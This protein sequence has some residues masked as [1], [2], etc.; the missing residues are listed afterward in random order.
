M[1]WN[2][3]V[4]TQWHWWHRHAV[5]CLIVITQNC[6]F[7]CYTLTGRWYWSGCSWF[8]AWAMVADDHE[9]FCPNNR[10][11]ISDSW[12]RSKGKQRITVG[13]DLPR[14]VCWKESNICTLGRPQWHS[15]LIH[16]IAFSI[17][18]CRNCWQQRFDIM[19]FVPL[20][21]RGWPS[22][23]V[24]LCLSKATG[25]KVPV[26]NLS[27]HPFTSSVETVLPGLEAKPHV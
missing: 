2:Q 18:R 25:F 13:A 12:T 4:P 1:S 24:E 27:L 15:F 3:P 11:P 19:I 7:P 22:H 16:F 26:T 9:L 5:Q 6:C 17:R 8:Q 23:S 10:V 21:T 14:G 20:V